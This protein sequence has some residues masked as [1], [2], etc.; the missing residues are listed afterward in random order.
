[1]V[2][3]TDPSTMPAQ[4]RAKRERDA[5]HWQGA[6]APVFV[7]PPS[8]LGELGTLL[9]AIDR[10]LA[11][12]DVSTLVRRAIDVARSHIGLD[13]VGVFLIDPKHEYMLGTWGTDRAGQI[14][15]QR[16]VKFAL[17]A[18]VV[19]VFLRAES[20]NQPFTVLE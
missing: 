12:G 15:D 9:A 18:D 13:R 16:R 2:R 6:T 7:R 4:H 3:A 14:V 11:A 19:D 5:A 10:L 1:M 8:P 20:G 17:D